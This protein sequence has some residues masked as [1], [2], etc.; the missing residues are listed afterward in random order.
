[1]NHFKAMTSTEEE[2]W[3]ALTDLVAVAEK[4]LG[5]FD[6]SKT[7]GGLAQA[8]AL[9]VMHSKYLLSRSN[10]EAMK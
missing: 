8:L 5:T 3:L 7:G 4:V 9:E 1:M 6:D 2:L 10:T